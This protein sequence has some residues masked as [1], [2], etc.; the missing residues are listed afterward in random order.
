MP[1]ILISDPISE[2]ALEEL[3]RVNATYDYMPEIPEEKLLTLIGEYEALVV[4]SRT[5]VTREVIERGQRLRVIGR[6]G[7]G[8]DNIDSEAAK[9]RGI[10]VLNTPDALTNAVAE[11]TIALMLDLSRRL[12]YSDYN[13][14]NGKWLKNQVSGRELKDKIYG[15]IGIGRIGSRVAELAHAFGMTIMANDVIPIPEGLIRSLQIKVSSQD[16]ILSEADFVDL[17]VPLLP[18]TTNLLNYAKISKMKRTAFLINTSRGKVINETDLLRALRENLIAG[19]AL[20]VFEKEPPDNS[21]LLRNEK[22]IVTPHIAGQTEEA[23]TSAGLSI[24][25]SVLDALKQ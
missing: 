24:I 9:Q 13:L 3:K 18:E 6:A 12:S 16:E 19:A 1:S 2:Q 4:R 25:R 15:T 5:K 20:D 21:D 10:T 11:F 23:Q 7:V 14:K 8:T 17:H 22:M